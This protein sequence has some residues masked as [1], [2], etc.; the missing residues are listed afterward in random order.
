MIIR[1]IIE[2]TETQTKETFHLICH[3][4][5]EGWE[6]TREEMEKL[7]DMAERS[8][9]GF[10]SRREKEA[11]PAELYDDLYRKYNLACFQLKQA[12]AK[13]SENLTNEVDQ[14][15]ECPDYIEPPAPEVVCENGVCQLVLPED[16]EVPETPSEVTESP[17]NLTKSEEKKPESEEKPQKSEPRDFSRYVEMDINGYASKAIMGAMAEDMGLSNATANNYFYTKVRPVAAKQKEDA[18]Q[19]RLR[20]IE[21]EKK[22]LERKLEKKIQVIPPAEP[23]SSKPEKGKYFSDEER[24]RIQKKLGLK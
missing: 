9:E 14:A 22:Q 23:K 3:E 2:V 6:L 24:L 12:T 20:A 15:E 17:E 8:L 19:A 10:Y 7:K 18:E 16:E 11:V 21:A 5:D 4:K 13:S 1:K